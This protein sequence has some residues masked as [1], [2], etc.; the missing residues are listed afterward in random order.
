M[1]TRLRAGINPFL[2]DSVTC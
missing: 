1:P 2:K